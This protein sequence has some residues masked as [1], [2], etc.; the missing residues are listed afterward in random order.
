[1]NMVAGST[2]S[3]ICAVSV[4]N[5]SC[6]TMNRSSR[7]KPLRTRF[8]SGAT[9]T[10]LVFWISIALTGPPPFNA[11]ASPV[12][13]RPIWDWSSQRVLRSS[14]SW[15]SMMNSLKCHSARLLKKAPPPSYCQ[16]PVTAG[17]QSAACICA[18]PLRLRVKP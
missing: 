7:A 6:T 4:M 18:A 1:M 10:G 14:A 11:S 5:C 8:C 16:A 2:I 17:M 12:R 13:M 15:P 3:A 9:V